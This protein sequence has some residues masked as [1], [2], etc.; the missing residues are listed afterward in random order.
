MLFRSRSF[1]VRSMFVATLG[2]AI[3]L[4]WLTPRPEDQRAENRLVGKWE[5][6]LEKI[7]TPLTAT[8]IVEFPPAKQYGI[9]NGFNNSQ[10]WRIR[11]GILC[12][13][14][15]VMFANGKSSDLYLEIEWTND[16]EFVGK[17]VGTNNTLYY[18][19]IR[20]DSK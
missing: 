14:V 5:V 18:R 10:F 20:P 9:S 13:R 2:V 17:V 8:R 1:T 6:R 12:S 11:D 3:T 7:R 19:R 16:D 15:R 4:W